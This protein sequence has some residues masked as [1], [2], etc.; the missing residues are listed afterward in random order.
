MDDGDEA[1]APMVL[2]LVR[3]HGEVRRGNADMMVVAEVIE[4]EGGGAARRRSS[5]KF[6]EL[7]RDRED[8]LGHGRSRFSRKSD[9]EEVGSIYRGLGLREGQQTDRN[10][11]DLGSGLSV[12]DEHERRRQRRGMTS[13]VHLS[14]AARKG[15]RVGWPTRRGLG[16]V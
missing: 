1:V 13:G 8:S 9:E 2:H 4:G 16:R 6:C 15:A 14:V 5:V 11:R 12:Y 7:R 10:R 3:E